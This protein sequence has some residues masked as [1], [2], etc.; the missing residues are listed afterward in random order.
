MKRLIWVGVLFAVCMLIDICRGA[1][2]E[3]PATTTIEPVVSS[4]FWTKAEIIRQSYLA[5][6][7][8]ADAITTQR[9]ISKGGG[10]RDPLAR[11]LVVMGWGGQVA[12]T[13]MAYGVGL[14]ARYMTR[15]R[16]PRLSKAITVGYGSAEW[17]C[18]GSNVE[19]LRNWRQGDGVRWG[20]GIR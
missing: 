20:Y 13:G 14:M 5:S 19:V 11:P 3:R 6:G 7:L 4:P 8:I 18:A 2:V 1:E 16:W 9:I 10:E 15:N 17:A 12:A